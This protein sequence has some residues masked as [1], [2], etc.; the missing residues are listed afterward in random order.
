[1]LSSTTTPLFLI[2]AGFC[3]DAKALAGSIRGE[4]I[5]IGEYEIDCGYP[6][7]ADL[8]GICFPDASPA[9]SAEQVERRLADALRTRERGP[10]QRLCDALMKADYYLASRLLGS[11]RP[12]PYSHLVDDFPE[13]SYLSFNYD[14]LLEFG[15]FRAG[16]WSPHDGYGV[17]VRVDLGFTA[18]PYE[19]RDSR[20]LVLHLHGSLL[21]YTQ[22]HA[23][24][25]VDRSGF[26]W[27][28][29]F[30][31]P[32]FMFDPHALGTLFYPFTRAVGGLG[33]NPDVT[34]RV[35]APVAEKAEGLRAEFVSSVR[36]R[37]L[38]LLGGHPTVVSIGYSFAEGDRGSYC[39]LLRALS[40]HERPR[41]V[42]VVPE[43]VPLAS[44][45]KEDFP[46]I[47]WEP[48]P[49]TFAEWVVRGYPG[50]ARGPREVRRAAP[51]SGGHQAAE[52]RPP[53]D[54]V[55]A[56]TPQRWSK[57]QH[58]SQ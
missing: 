34:E 8:P 54:G 45:L 15:L 40:R 31:P 20:S 48:Q 52:L 38:N 24:G 5:Y 56:E 55:E 39:E 50:V 1:M 32:K 25:P 4:S 18:Q 41:V 58:S 16:R 3:A 2:G 10:L 27:M 26:R 17:P 9:V 47:V 23:F 29:R 51:P 28:E 19:I 7:V 35:I 22:H 11:G 13:S 14:A 53:S 6:L 42:L 43:A 44:R 49:M 37:A 21:V 46:N 36:A 33:Y 30:D 12:N 57:T